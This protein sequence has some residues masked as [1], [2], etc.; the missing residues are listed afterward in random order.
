[1]IKKSDNVCLE[2]LYLTRGDP[3]NWK[4]LSSAL[5]I[6]VFS[7]PHSNKFSSTIR[8]MLFLWLLSIK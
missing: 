3:D 2:S 5:L 8:N 7:A 1:M 4:H 6:L